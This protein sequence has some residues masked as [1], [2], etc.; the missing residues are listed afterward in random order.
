M[1]DFHPI[2]NQ[3]V[4]TQEQDRTM[5]TL[6]LGD[7]AT[8]PIKDAGHIDISQRKR[9][10]WKVNSYIAA[11]YCT[12]GIVGAIGA[13][14]SRSASTQSVQ[15]PGNFL[16]KMWRDLGQSHHNAKFDKGA[17]NR[18]TMR[19]L[20]GEFTS[21]TI[22]G[23][24]DM[25]ARHV[26]GVDRSKPGSFHRDDVEGQT[27]GH[28][29][30][31]RNAAKP[32]YSQMREELAHMVKSGRISGPRILAE[33]SPTLRAGFEMYAN[34]DSATENLRFMEWSGPI[35][36]AED[37]G[38]PRPITNFELA[39]AKERMIKP[40]ARN[41]INT[42]FKQR[43]IAVDAI[44]SAV[45]KE[46]LN[47]VASKLREID[48]VKER[49]ASGNLDF[50]ERNDATRRLDNLQFQL[51]LLEQ[52]GG[53]LDDDA[54]ADVIQGIR[55]C[56]EA[57][58]RRLQPSVNRFKSFVTSAADRTG[59]HDASHMQDM[60]NRIAAA[61]NRFATQLEES[62]YSQNAAKWHADQVYAPALNMPHKKLASEKNVTTQLAKLDRK[63][64]TFVARGGAW[65]EALSGL[66]TKLRIVA[67]NQTGN[68]ALKARTMLEDLPRL[69][70]HMPASLKEIPSQIQQMERE[71][72]A[73]GFEVDRQ[74]MIDGMVA[75]GLNREEAARV[76]NQAWAPALQRLPDDED[77]AAD[78]VIGISDHKEALK[79]AEKIQ[80][81]FDKFADGVD[82]AV[83]EYRNQLV[84]IGTADRKV[85]PYTR[86]F[87][88]HAM[89]Q[90]PESNSAVNSQLR[91]LQRRIPTQV[92]NDTSEL[93]V[94]PLR[95]LNVSGTQQTIVA[96]DGQKG[97]IGNQLTNMINGY[98]DDDD[99]WPVNDS[100]NKDVYGGCSRDFGRNDYTINGRQVSKNGDENRSV[101]QQEAEAR[102][103]L[104]AANVPENELR[105][106]TAL[107]HQG[108]G[109]VVPECMSTFGFKHGSRSD[110]PVHLGY[111]AD[112]QDNGTY[113]FQMTMRQPLT[114]VTRNPAFL[115]PLEDRMEK[116]FVTDPTQSNATMTVTGTLDP[117]N[118]NKVTITDATMGY[119]AVA[120]ATQYRPENVH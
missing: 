11:T 119:T 7:K 76:A 110:G 72:G 97:T 79:N 10:G 117:K 83:Q 38:Q 75:R 30:V 100:P 112:R 55:V 78:P 5:Q 92:A 23:K 68:G 16:K 69:R 49:L 81:R 60:R 1:T 39:V 109:K 77:P 99:A 22:G 87:R 66:E 59:G 56:D 43:N 104:L 6:D 85:E 46:Y 61:H 118:G 24:K 15:E 52:Q 17:F 3:P 103:E 67:Q 70:A 8:A 51:S 50:G 116:P 63:A 105:P 82:E 35:I 120:Q 9:G 102:Q 98:V 14:A 86:T 114:T 48:R 27:I 62:G 94:P 33:G 64:E 36:E 21:P 107:L 45:P 90:M 25:A 12:F 2:T 28:M 65:Q 41:E 42:D 89:R 19:L 73:D 47:N 44:E 26:Q 13:F 58:V 106:L 57:V 37:K 29:G 4:R 93:A 34:R 31:L 80:A 113:Q 95:G 108:I 54:R 88:Q 115:N 32:I 40:Y 84:A 20:S 18:G 91:E 53:N 71:L 74:N 101:D 96:D 111:T